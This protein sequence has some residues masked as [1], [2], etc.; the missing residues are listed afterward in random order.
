MLHRSA[1]TA[2]DAEMRANMRWA[3]PQRDAVEGLL[4]REMEAEIGS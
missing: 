4:L 2:G 3:T 1:L